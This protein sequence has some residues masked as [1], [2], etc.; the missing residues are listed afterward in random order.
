MENL[1]W[2]ITAYPE[3]AE[4]QDECHGNIARL[5]KKLNEEKEER[6]KWADVMS[7]GDEQDG[8]HSGGGGDQEVKPG[9]PV[10][11]QAD[12]MVGVLEDEQENDL[13]KSLQNAVKT[14]CPKSNMW[15]KTK[16]VGKR[17]GS[18]VGSK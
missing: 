3:N 17:N 13:I 9:A 15:R 14:S 11:G 12:K 10:C 5:K 7:S 2:M 4:L 1:L 18:H 6:N 8:G 16:L